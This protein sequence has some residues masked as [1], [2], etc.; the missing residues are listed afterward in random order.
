MSKTLIFFAALCFSLQSYAQKVKVTMFRDTA[1]DAMWSPVDSNVIAYSAKGK[2]MYYDIHIA[3]PDRKRDVCI[4]CDSPLLP[5]RHIAN[6][7]WHPSGKWLLAVVEKKEHPRSSANSLPGFGA[8]CDI[9][10]ISSDGKKAFK[11]VDIPNDFDHGVIMPKFSPDGTKIMWTDRF[12]RPGIMNAERHFGFWTVKL[13]DFSWGKDSVPSIATP[14][15]LFPGYHS[16]IEAYGFSPDGKKI[17][18]CGS[19]TTKS[20][21]QS[22]MFVMNIDGTGLQQ[23]TQ[24]TPG[25]GDYN[26]HGVFTPD[27]NRIIWMSNK[28]NDNKGT[29]WW[30][31]NSDGTNKKRL[32]FFNTPG[33]PMYVGKARWTGLVSFSPNGKRLIGGIQKSL[34]TQEGYIV[35]VDLVE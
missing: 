22:Q 15:D 20:A 7:S 18:F 14:N 30:I 2:D 23:L 26:E 33:D 12:R 1:L 16:F 17:I 35:L 21:W 8:Y 3:S 10:L 13:A 28:D 24:G 27:G 9:W 11:L 31:M 32:T 4:T 19:F 25:K 5:N 29:D 6:M 34:I